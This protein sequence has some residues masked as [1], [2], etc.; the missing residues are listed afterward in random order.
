MEISVLT[1]K[2]ADCGEIFPVSEFT[3][4][5]RNATTTYTVCR[6]CRPKFHRKERKKKRELEPW[7]IKF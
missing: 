2:C 3:T 7:F 4:R 5:Y 1:K 6:K